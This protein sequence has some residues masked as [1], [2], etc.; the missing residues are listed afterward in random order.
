MDM[1]HMTWKL[2]EWLFAVVI[3]L[4]LTLAI[5]TMVSFLVRGCR[6]TVVR[7][8]GLARGFWTVVVRFGNRQVSS[9][10]W[11]VLGV[12]LL[13]GL[14]SRLPPE[15]ALG[16]GTLVIICLIGLIASFLEGFREAL[17]GRRLM[18]RRVTNV[19]VD[20]SIPEENETKAACPKCGNRE[21]F[22][23]TYKVT[24]GGTYTLSFFTCKHP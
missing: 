4:G 24:N 13:F 2:I 18:P 19:E 6:E 10:A 11:L 5:V 1:I 23:R 20:R 9:T 7:I 16:I 17:R 15:I 3:L 8:P 12:A 21:T 14:S 22:S